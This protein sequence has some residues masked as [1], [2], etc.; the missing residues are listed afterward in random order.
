MEHFAMLD[1]DAQH[2][3]FEIPPLPF[4]RD[5]DRE[6]LAVALGATLYTPGTRADLAQVV[7]RRARDGVTSIVLCLED[8]IPDDRVEEATENVVTAVRLLGRATPSA[9]PLIF[10]RVR[11]PSQILELGKLLG[12]DLAR[13]SGFVMPKINA[14]NADNYFSALTKVQRRSP[15]KLYAMPVLEDP[16]II[17]AHTR[18][19]ALT[20]LERVL[21]AHR[22]QV[23]ALRIGATDFMA[24]YGLRRTP[25]Q[26]VYDVKVVSDVLSDIV[27]RLGRAD[28]TG[29]VITAPVWEFFTGGERIFRPALRLSLFEQHNATS[30]REQLIS[31]EMDALIR[32]V[33]L[34]RANGFRGKTVIHPS[35]VLVVNALQVVTHEE[36]SDALEVLGGTGGASSSSYRNKM[37]E[38]KPHS[39]WAER[40]MLRAK[41]FGVARP[42]VSFVEVL[43]ESVMERT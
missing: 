19:K 6:T 21:S 30:L 43:A 15:S 29:F 8:S 33:D 32:E 17:H 11:R 16:Q 40:I 25:D 7:E 1:D 26:T 36:Y 5:A 37:N 4:Q 10:I 13:L 14:D 12:S 38:T 20:K 34:D 41:V 22:E 24:A 42:D 23:L 35:H 28:G 3:I 31:R 39:A 2:R 27:N 18:Q 9:G